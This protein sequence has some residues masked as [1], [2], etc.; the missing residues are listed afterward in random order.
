MICIHLTHRYQAQKLCSKWFHLLSYVLPLQGITNEPYFQCLTWQYRMF[1]W[2]KVQAGDNVKDDNFKTSKNSIPKK[3]PMLSGAHSLLIRNLHI[4]QC[5]SYT[6]RRQ[7][8]HYTNY[9]CKMI[10]ASDRRCGKRATS[11][12]TALLTCHSHRNQLEPIWNSMSPK[13]HSIL[14]Q[15][16][17]TKPRLF[18][19]RN[20]SMSYTNGEER[21][22]K[23]VWLHG[24]SCIVMKGCYGGSAMHA[25]DVK[26]LTW[27]QMHKDKCKTFYW[28]FF[29]FLCSYSFTVWL[30]ED[31]ETLT[32]LVI[33][34]VIY[35]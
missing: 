10:R 19:N 15:A 7:S 28:I 29:F 35:S 22:I 24:R 4:M 21:R 30:I 13:S 5:T 18:S 33:I 17:R 34:C 1:F 23:L 32:L 25:S 6:E 9:L 11:P 8:D 16:L 14:I 31:S 26:W 27:G 12:I 2:T 3:N 20:W